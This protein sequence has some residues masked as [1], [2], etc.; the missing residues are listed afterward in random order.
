M[1]KALLVGINHYEGQGSNLEGCVK[2]VERMEDLLSYSYS[3]ENGEANERNF[4]CKTF[5]SQDKKGATQITRSVLRSEIKALFDDPE[6]DVALFYFSGHGFNCSLGGYLATQDAKSY[7]E[8]ISFNEI[9]FYANNSTN[10]E[11][12]IILDCCHS[13]NFGRILIANNQLSDIREGVCVLTASTAKQL[14]WDSSGGAVFTNLICNALKGGNSDLTGNVKITH[15]YQH[16]ERMLGPWEQRPTFKINTE[17]L[18]VLRK[19]EPKVPFALLSK[20]LDYFPNK[21]HLIDLSPEFEPTEKNVVKKKA[22][23]LTDLQKLANNGLVQPVDEEHM[24][25]AAINSKACKLTLVG[26]QYWS[27]LKNKGLKY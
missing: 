19:T 20:I 10:K 17:N 12:I 9:I 5:K 1:K 2:D 24:Y 21:D 16:A 7:D 27:L 23:I 25:Y 14:S 6:A 11:I 18:I 3:S 8:G 13:G 15:L 22:L 26:K 4:F